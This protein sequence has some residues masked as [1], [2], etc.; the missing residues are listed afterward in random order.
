MYQSDR[1]HHVR[2]CIATIG[3]LCIKS[4]LELDVFRPPALEFVELEQQARSLHHMLDVSE[5]AYTA[6]ANNVG[7][8][9]IRG[10]HGFYGD[11]SGGG[12]Q[13]YTGRG[14]GDCLRHIRLRR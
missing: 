10:N 3:Y 1:T 13:F 8:K 5:L 2:D 6:C 9:F 11:F 7:I 4:L 14:G 12:H